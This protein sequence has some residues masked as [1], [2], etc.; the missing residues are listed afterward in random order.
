MLR[1]LEGLSSEN[2]GASSS[3]AN[4]AVAL[5]GN[6]AACSSN[7]CGSLKLEM[8]KR[9]CTGTAGQGYVS[10]HSA[11]DGNTLLHVLQFNSV[12][13]GGST[14]LKSSAAWRLGQWPEQTSLT[15]P[16]QQ[17]RDSAG[18]DIKVEMALS[19]CRNNNQV[20]LEWTALQCRYCG[21]SP[22]SAAS[23]QA[24]RQLVGPFM[25]HMYRLQ[26]PRPCLGQSQSRIKLLVL[27][28]EA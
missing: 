3:T 16:P 20:K 8:T 11:R 4:A 27:P 10:S 7:S 5:V 21:W 17:A 2:D 26:S 6:Y 23:L 12:L 15:Q 13:E 18:H 28:I 25:P 14:A 1:G 19:M 24:A 22:T 9:A